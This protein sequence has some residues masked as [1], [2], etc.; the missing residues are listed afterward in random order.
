MPE[1]RNKRRQ[2]TDEIIGGINNN[3]T[4][5]AFPPGGKEKQDKRERKMNDEK[6]FLDEEEFEEGDEEIITLA[7]PDGEEVDFT[8]IATVEFEGNLY[9]IM[10][11]V[12]L[13]EGMDEDEALVFSVTDEGE[14]DSRFDVVTDERVIDGVFGEYNKLFEEQNKN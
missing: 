13:F 10:Q 8:Q 6:D 4:Q 7:T 2:I 3:I 11:P 9:V 14:E 1:R 5:V 12:E